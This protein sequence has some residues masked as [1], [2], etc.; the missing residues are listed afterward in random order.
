[1][2]V[3][4]FYMDRDFEK[5]RRIMPGRSTLNTNAAAEHVPEMER[6]IR[7]IK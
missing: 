3:E 2:C 7:V 1:M 4:I 5:I 6:Q